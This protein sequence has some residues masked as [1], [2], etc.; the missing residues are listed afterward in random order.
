MRNL[1]AA[2]GVS[3]LFALP[4]CAQQKSSGTG[5]ETTNATA[6]EEKSAAPRKNAEVSKPAAASGLFALPATPRPKPFPGPA[7]ASDK[8]APGQ[9]VPRFEIAGMYDYLNFAPGNPFPNFD[10]HG[11]S[12][13]LTYNASKWIG[14]TGEVGTYDLAR[15][16]I[17]SFL[18]GPRLNLRKFDYFVPFGEFLA[19][20]ARG[21]GQIT[22]LGE[23]NAFALAAGG[24]VDMILSKNF[25]WRVAQLDYF[26]T[27]F[28]GPAV[29]ASGRQNSF[30]AG[31]GFVLRF[32]IP[33][34]PPPP[35][36]PPVAACSASTSSSEEH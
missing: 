23:Q 3:V 25:A 4:L 30:R 15:G 11:G 21:N 10:G 1:C 6:S 13:S 29:T 12:G 31:T 35:N 22:G 5:D 16:T 28:T 36:H 8:R 19:G 24:G 14:L 27:S 9:L 34:P 2:L 33:N 26:M 20:A 17:T 32:G 18:F 7:A